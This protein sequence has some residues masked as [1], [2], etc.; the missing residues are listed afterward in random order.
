MEKLKGQDKQQVSQL[1]GQNADV[2]ML[3]LNTALLMGKKKDEELKQ[4]VESCVKSNSA[5]FTAQLIV[6]AR[7][8]KASKKACNQA[9]VYLIPFTAKKPWAKRFFSNEGVMV[10]LDDT[11]NIMLNYL[12]VE[13]K[14]RNVT[15]FSSIPYPNALR[16]GV[17]ITLENATWD[18]FVKYNNSTCQLKLVD[19]V[20]YCHPN[21]SKA[22]SQ[23]DIPLD[24]YV[25]HMKTRLSKA[26]DKRAIKKLISEA[27]ERAVDGMITIDAF[28]GLIHEIIE[29][30][31]TKAVKEDE[32]RLSIV[33]DADELRNNIA[34]VNL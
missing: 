23:K 30:D 2:S 34:D 27:E 13:A 14:K 11:V 25:A 6:N 21:P 22:K 12:M 3:A 5:Y 4:L 31:T 7:K 33:V 10:E 28:H 9:A 1:T 26:T 8:N 29:R 17:M 32:F 20:K 16:K 19:A 24:D 18:D 15:S